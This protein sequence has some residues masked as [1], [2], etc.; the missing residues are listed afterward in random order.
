MDYRIL[1]AFLTRAYF[2]GRAYIAALLEN[3]AR[4]YFQ[5]RSNFWGNGIID[6]IRSCLCCLLFYV[7]VYLQGI[8]VY[9]KLLLQVH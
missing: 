1:Q 5:D 2:R 7:E 6:V 8:C 4:S 9:V 3:K